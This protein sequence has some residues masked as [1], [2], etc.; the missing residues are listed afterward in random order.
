MSNQIVE[1]A[2]GQ[3]IQYV[4]LDRARIAVYLGQGNP[5]G[6]GGRKYKAAGMIR[7]RNATRP[8]KPQG[9]Q[10]VPKGQREGGEIFAS[11]ELCKRSLEAA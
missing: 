11:V 10:Y 2:G 9:W 8:D 3:S 6:P 7:R 1:I 5:R 4:E